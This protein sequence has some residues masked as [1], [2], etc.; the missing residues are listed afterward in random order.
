MKTLIP[1][2][3]LVVATAAGS[4]SAQTAPDT[5]AAAGSD[6]IT[7]APDHQV[8]RRSAAESILL[9]N[10]SDHYLVRFARSC[11]SA[12]T[13]RKVEFVTPDH[14]GQLCGAGGSKL[15]T[16]SQ[17]CEVTAVQPITAEVFTRR[18]R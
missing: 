8:V 15:R 12:A 5:A 3:L 14:Q 10:G 1:L 18:A 6:C 11:S 9:Q 17:S 16:D 7:L 4:A 13:S 2:C